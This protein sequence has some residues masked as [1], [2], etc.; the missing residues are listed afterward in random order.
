MDT[1]APA[2]RLQTFMD[3]RG[4]TKATAATLFG[5]HTSMISLVLRGKRTPGLGLALTIERETRGIR[6]G[7]IRPQSWQDARRTTPKR[8][9]KAA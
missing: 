6:G 3:A 5:C 2:D 8:T 1:P 7:A 4:L 9:R